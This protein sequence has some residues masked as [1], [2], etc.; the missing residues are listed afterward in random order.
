MGMIN[1]AGLAVVSSPSRSKRYGQLFKLA[2]TVELLTSGGDT[3]IVCD[4]AHGQNKY[5]CSPSPEPNI[6]AYGSSTASTITPG[7]FAA[8]ERLRRRL[9]RDAR[10]EGPSI[11][12]ARELARVRAELLD[13]CD[14]ADIPG[15]D[16]VFAASGTDLHL[17]AAQLASDVKTSALLAVM[18]EATETGSGV[19]A[20]LAGR[21]FSD[22]TALGS[23]VASDTSILGGGAIEVAAVA[24]RATD[25]TPRAAALIDAEVKAL[26]ASAAMAGRRVL[27]NLVDVSKTGMI[28]PSL[29][30]ALELRRRFPVAVDVLVDGCQFRLAPSTLRAYLQHGFWIALTGSKFVGGPAF[31]GALILPDAA[32]RRLR[33]RHLP[34]ALSAYS[35]RA[36]WPPGWTVRH[37]LADVENFGLLLRWEAALAEL[38]TF[39]SLSEAAITTFLEAFAGK[40]RQ[41][42]TTDPIFQLLPVPNL[43]RRPLVNVNSWDHTPTIFSFILRHAPNSERLG[44]PLSRK[45]TA[46]VYKLLGTDSLELSTL[47]PTATIGAIAARRCQL[48]QPVHCGTIDDVPVSALRLCVSMR[49]VVDAVSRW[50]RGAEIVN[51]EG[52]LALD[53]A[54]L[55]SSTIDRL[56]VEN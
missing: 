25:G 50:G 31:S 45:E 12:Y 22:C 47:N 6:L 41:R 10:I 40:V 13:L 26:V 44:A 30:C 20:A 55:L 35:A 4:P 37:A 49:L 54:A 51:A 39:R 18:I 21:H 3:R 16:I 17:I 32:A 29:A 43:D 23:I 7:S 28:A 53:N 24:S 5:G 27:L 48:G 11:T 9:Q 52:L 2:P 33:T 14:L 34:P 56:S 42:L 1:Q 46:R 19:P 38:R 36:D 8:A 15:V